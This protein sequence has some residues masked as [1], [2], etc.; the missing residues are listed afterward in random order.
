MTG[1]ETYLVCP[2]CERTEPADERAPCPECGS[3]R[4]YLSHVPAAPDATSESY[5][6]LDAED[7]EE[8]E[9]DE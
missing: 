2:A 4:A 6:K 5:V 3:E 7:V 1:E 9:T 8:K